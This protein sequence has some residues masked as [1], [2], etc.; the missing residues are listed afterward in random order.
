[1]CPA[2][3]P[4]TQADTEEMLAFIRQSDRPVLPDKAF[5]LRTLPELLNR[6]MGKAGI[7]TDV[8]FELVGMNRSTGYRIL[9]GQRR[10]SRDVLI[11]LTLAL[12]LGY[13]EAQELLK[14]GRM[15]LLSPRNSRD[16]L[17]LFAIMHGY[18]LGETNDLLLQQEHKPLLSGE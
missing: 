16:F 15:A 17:I 13:Q 6:H 18:G 14:A 10:P 4:P 2:I 8:L 5:L 9:G 1:M 3:R 12:K 7:S 11:A